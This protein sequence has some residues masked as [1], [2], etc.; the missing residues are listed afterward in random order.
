M[1]ICHSYYQ[2]WGIFMC[3][4]STQLDV[5]LSCFKIMDCLP[6]LDILAGKKDEK[7]NIFLLETKQ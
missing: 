5:D 1:L 7:Y 3:N 6:F 2:Q 4:A